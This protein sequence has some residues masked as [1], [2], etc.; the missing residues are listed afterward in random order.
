LEQAA[1]VAHCNSAR[2]IE[3]A[4]DLLWQFDV[5]AAARGHA[6]LISDVIATPRAPRRWA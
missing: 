6:R 4:S 5:I 1:G 2:E 3:A